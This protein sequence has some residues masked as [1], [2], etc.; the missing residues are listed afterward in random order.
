MLRNEEVDERI[1]LSIAVLS[2]TV[3]RVRTNSFLKRADEDTD[4][5]NTTW[6]AHG[7]PPFGQFLVDEMVQNGWCPFDVDRIDKTATSATLLYYLAELPPPRPNSDH[8]L[9]TNDTCTSMAI[10]S[11]YR[12]RHSST[13]CQCNSEFSDTT[14]VIKALQGDEIPLIQEVLQVEMI[15]KPSEES[16]GKNTWGFVEA[17]TLDPKFR[18]VES[19]E[20]QPFVAV[21]HVWAKGLGNPNSNSLPA[22]ALKWI[23]DKA[24]QFVFQ[25]DYPV[26]SQEEDPFRIPRARKVP[27]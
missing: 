25:D 15:E 6:R 1:W 10:D 7:N 11:S 21:S 3:E 8:S 24:S 19:G 26:Q 4:E 27:F 22:C 14:N 17:T 18:I 5:Q 23:S 13:D 20:G 2:E 9:C 12:P 16:G